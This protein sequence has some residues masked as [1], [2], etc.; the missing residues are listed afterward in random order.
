MLASGYLEFIQVSL[1]K[2]A[3]RKST[4]FTTAKRLVDKADVILDSTKFFIDELPSPYPDSTVKT[5]R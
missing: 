1:I 4:V 5:G 3:L 2:L